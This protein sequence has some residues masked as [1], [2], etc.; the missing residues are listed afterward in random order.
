MLPEHFLNIK[1][2][3]L[4]DFLAQV[5]RPSLFSTDG[6]TKYAFSLSRVF[7]RKVWILFKVEKQLS[8]STVVMGHGCGDEKVHSTTTGFDDETQL[9][10]ARFHRASDRPSCRCSVHL[11]ETPR[12]TV[13]TCP[14]SE[15]PLTSWS[16]KEKCCLVS[17]Y[18]ITDLQRQEWQK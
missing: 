14:C 17:R 6:T 7:L 4:N 15:L 2:V 18:A 1:F 8:A 16:V 10:S 12:R 13:Q 11:Q 5:G 9:S 3:L